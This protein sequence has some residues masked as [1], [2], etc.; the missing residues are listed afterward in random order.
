MKDILS[1]ASVTSKKR[2][3]IFIVAYNAEKTIESVLTRIP[4]S[5]GDDF[6][7]EILVI[8][9]ASKD[10]TFERGELMRRSND[11][12]FVLHVLFNP[13]NQ[14]YGGNQKIGFHYAIENN[15]DFVVLLHGDGQYA[16]ELLP[17]LLVPLAAGEADA[18]FG[19]RMI[20]RGG[21]LKGGMPLYKYVGNKV[22]TYI[23]NTLLGSHLSE[24]HS[25]Y[26]LYSINALKRIPFDKNSNV[27]HF[28]T[29][30]IIQLMFAGLK[31]KEIPIPTYYGDEICYV[32][33]M[34]YATDVLIATA[35]ARM[36][37]MGLFYDRKFDCRND[38]PINSHYQIK[39]GYTSPH[40]IVLDKVKAGS[41]VLDLGCAGGYLSAK[42]QERGCIITGIDVA[43]LENGITLDEFKIHD[44]NL[45]LPVDASKFDYILLMDVIEHL[46]SP[47]K[48]VENLLVSMKGKDNVE[49]LVS[50]GNVA[51]CLVRFLLLFGQF[52]YGKRGILDL[53]HTRLFTAKTL[54][55]LFLQNGYEIV[56]CL[57]VPAPFPLAVGNNILGRAMCK[58]NDW[59]I[60]LSKSLFSYQIFY[61]IRAKPTLASLLKDAY[62]SSSSRAEVFDE[63]LHVK[64]VSNQ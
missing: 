26:R 60:Y 6:D 20:S 37:K 54:R 51:F 58:I 9:D 19:S 18:V 10:N 21:A 23:Q 36:Q 47:E 3:L 1:M 33:G 27:F 4:K 30:I 41:R 62:E 24:F 16:P 38:A 42:L 64:K 48:F 43:P 44:L 11:L 52:N 32:N 45:P 13:K 39:L 55:Q 34:R 2:L 28:D 7:T 57:G 40:T 8:D 59:F 29:E 35:K 46:N 53:T 49:I 61:V 56:E 15:F 17:V 5:L 22:L 63:T 14:G 25:G 50:S 12:P 31:I